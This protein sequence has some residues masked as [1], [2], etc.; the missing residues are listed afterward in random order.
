MPTVTRTAWRVAC[1]R[2]DFPERSRLISSDACQHRWRNHAKFNNSE[3]EQDGGRWQ[4]RR[5]AGTISGRF[6]DD[7][8]SDRQHSEEV[9]HP[10]TSRCLSPSC[11][12]QMVRH[13]RESAW[14]HNSSRQQLSHSG[15]D[16]EKRAT[17]H[18]RW[19]FYEEG[20]L[21]SAGMKR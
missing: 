5:V 2:I 12:S 7:P 6:E 14:E 11:P 8:D 9:K 3:N 21:C 13:V 10:C 17:N 4:W 20:R 15:C 19:S 16:A 18:L 1:F